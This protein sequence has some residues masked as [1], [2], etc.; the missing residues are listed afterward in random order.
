MTPE[1][2]FVERLRAMLP[3]DERVAV[4][5]GDDAAVLRLTGGELAVTTDMMVEGVDFFPGED[6]RR[7]GRR[8][9][10]VNL[11]D[12]AAMGAHPEFFLL[13]IGFPPEKG[14][15]FPLEVARGALTRA[16]P[17]G[18]SLVGG[19]LSGAPATVVSVALWGRPSG[20]PLLRSGGRE[21]DFLFVSGWPGRAEAG[22]RLAAGSFP[23]GALVIEHERELLAAYHDPEPRVTLGLAL[24]REGLASA[25]IDVSDGVGLDAGRL[26]RASGAR[27]VIELGE[28]PI[29]P[30]LAEAARGKGEDPV[31]WALSGGDDYEL[32]FSAP[33]SALARLTAGGPDW[34][35][36]VTRIGRLEPGAGAVAIGPSGERDIAALGW[37]HLGRRA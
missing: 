25:A 27:A 12:L 5:P 17:F 16:R 14:D 9:L 20:R 8:A 6:P 22:R 15:D 21:G 28:I 19:D 30:A 3:E 4:G 24:A 2:R 7:L 1:D 18:A 10:A 33:P 11:S 26:A 37:N 23:A 31:E 29:S 34:N 35:V 36:P 32:L 13:S